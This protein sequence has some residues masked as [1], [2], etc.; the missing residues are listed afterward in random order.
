[1]LKYES[2]VPWV[3]TGMKMMHWI[4]LAAKTSLWL[5][6]V[7]NCGLFKYDCWTEENCLLV[8]LQPV[9]WRV[10][11]RNCIQSFKRQE[12]PLPNCKEFTIQFHAHRKANRGKALWHNV[13]FL[14]VLNYRHII[15]TFICR[16]GSKLAFWSLQWLW[17]SPPWVFSFCCLL[18]AIS[19]GL[20]FN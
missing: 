1:M 9:V 4:S 13:S 12:R 8:V 10:S 6:S 5:Y 3:G 2:W 17:S 15:Y 11:V 20:Y 7:Y 16:Q 19:F 18:I 14:H